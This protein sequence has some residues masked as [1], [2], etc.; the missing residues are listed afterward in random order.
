MRS[1]TKPTTS[2]YA[3]DFKTMISVRREYCAD[4][5]FFLMTS[6]WDSLS[7]GDSSIS[8]KKYRSSTGDD[9]LRRAAVHRFDDQIKLIVDRALWEN[10]ERG[11]GVFNFLLAHECA[12]VCLDHHRNGHGV[13]N[14]KMA[15]SRFGVSATA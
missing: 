14:F 11:N 8:I 15:Q 2:G 6:F 13:K 1:F 5:E 4:T 9:F 7:E 10:A 3:K 12:H